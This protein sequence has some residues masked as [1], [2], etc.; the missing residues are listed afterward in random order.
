MKPSMSIG[1]NYRLELQKRLRSINQSRENKLSLKILDE[2]CHLM[3]SPT[4]IK[5]KRYKKED[6]FVEK[7][8][9]NTSPRV[10][11]LMVEYILI[12]F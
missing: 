2:Q 9:S 7:T 3:K 5:T 8:K 12:I 4:V 11:D 1:R 6:K 10:V